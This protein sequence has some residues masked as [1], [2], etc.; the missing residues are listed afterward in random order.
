VLAGTLERPR[1]IAAGEIKLA[2]KLSFAERLAQL[3]RDVTRLVIEFVPLAAAVEAPFQGVSAR[4]ALQLAHARG[5]I[6]SVL[7]EAGIPVFEYAP[8]T[9]KKSVTGSGRAEKQ[10]VQFMVRHLVRGAGA[11]D[12]EDVSDAIAA[13][14]CHLAGTIVSAPLRTQR[15]ER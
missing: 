3:H 7:G 13:A 1:L 2:D 14:L 4:S 9:I 10:Q 6:L 15:L 12:G 11:H 5:V 8:A